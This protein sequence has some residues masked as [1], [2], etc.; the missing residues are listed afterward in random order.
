MTQPVVRLAMAE[1]N[2]R[3]RAHEITPDQYA[4][5]MEDARLCE[6]RAVRP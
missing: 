4:A 1:L 6:M 5:G 3:Y 2:R